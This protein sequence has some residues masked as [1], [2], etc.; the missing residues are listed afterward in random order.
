MAQFDVHKHAVGS[1]FSLLLNVQ[2]DDVA[3]IEGR[4]VVPL[5]AR[6]RYGE[7]PIP[8]LNPVA[9][10]AGTEFVLLFQ[11]LAA[12]P[13]TVLGERVDSLAHR[14]ADIIAALDL[15]FTGS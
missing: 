6:R 11:D 1:P 5:V 12:V 4:V 10:I 13:M 7:K 15:L 8:R 3:R 9:T 2:A 14:R